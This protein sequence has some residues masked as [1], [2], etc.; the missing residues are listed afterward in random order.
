MKLAAIIISSLLLASLTAAT[1]EANP[2]N[3]K[4]TQYLKKDLQRHI[5]KENWVMVIE[6]SQ[7]LGHFP[8]TIKPK[9]LYYVGLAYF[10]EN[11]PAMA[12]SFFNRFLSIN[13][14]TTKNYQSASSLLQQLKQQLP[15]YCLENSKACTQAATFDFLRNK[16]KG[17]LNIALLLNQYS[18]EAGNA[19]AC[20]SLGF[21]HEN[22]FAVEKNPAVAISLYTESCNKKYARACE[23]LGNLYQSGELVES[24][25]DKAISYY[26]L[27]CQYKK[28]GGCEQ[29]KKLDVKYSHKARPIS[30]FPPIYPIRAMMNETQGSCKMLFDVSDKGKVHNIR[31]TC[32]NK[33]FLRNAKASLRKWKYEPKVVD[34][35]ATAST[36][37]TTK[38][39]F[40]LN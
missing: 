32:T 9:N 19:K 28:A 18:C 40:K 24:D 5:N 21:M 37:R 25:L 17:D 36:D 12:T 22:G 13:Q 4:F 10:H 30:R 39:A 2:N 16:D 6:T 3:R 33:V 14:P 27:D 15:D 26:R 8:E 20:F 1:A 35:I 34:G 23:Q 31:A 38:I 29:L 11:Q 7:V